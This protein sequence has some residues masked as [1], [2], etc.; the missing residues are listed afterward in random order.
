MKKCSTGVSSI[1]I[2]LTM[3]SVKIFHLL[4]KLKLGHTHGD[5]GDFTRFVSQ[6]SGI[7]YATNAVTF[8]K[9]L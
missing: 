1:D 4:E 9:S 2:M 7:K 5:C 8:Y 6:P 3:C